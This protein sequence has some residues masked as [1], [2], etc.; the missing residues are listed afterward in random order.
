MI[1]IGHQDY[2]IFEPAKLADGSVVIPFRWFTRKSGSGS[3]ATQ[4]YWAE[5]WRLEPIITEEGCRGYVVNKFDTAE[6]PADS[7][8]QSM[9]HLVQTYASDNLPDP[10]Y[11]IGTLT[12]YPIKPRLLRSRGASY[13]RSQCP[14]MWCMP[15]ETYECNS[16]KSLA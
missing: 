8:L 15:M 3:L 12:S 16:R 13:R 7:F 1:R 10:R 11:I 5:V 4:K 14:W 2:Y 6:V 9:P